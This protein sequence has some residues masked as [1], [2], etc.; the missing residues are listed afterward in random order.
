MG[1]APEHNGDVGCGEDGEHEV[2][3]KEVLQHQRLARSS[4]ERS[5]R[6]ERLGCDT[7]D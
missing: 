4:I 6:L 3:G 7:M 2:E 1:A 5:A